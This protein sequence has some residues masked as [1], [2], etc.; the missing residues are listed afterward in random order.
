MQYKIGVPIK[1]EIKE[2]VTGIREWQYYD[3][4]EAFNHWER[5]TLKHVRFNLHS[6]TV[7]IIPEP[8]YKVN[9]DIVLTK[10]KRY[11]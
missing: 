4:E 2:S 3:I 10:T 1:G 9:N 5:E 8:N 7:R 11:S 6:L